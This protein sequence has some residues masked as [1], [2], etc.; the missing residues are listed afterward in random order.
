[1]NR[2]PPD[3]I[4]KKLRQEVNFGC[5]Y[6]DCGKPVLS[7]HHFDPLWSDKEHHDAAGMIALCP[8]HHAFADGGHYTREQLKNWKRNPNSIDKVRFEIPWLWDNFVYEIGTSYSKPSSTIYLNGHKLLQATRDDNSSPWKLSVNILND[9]GETIAKIDN[10]FLIAPSNFADICLS[11]Q[12]KHLNIT[13]KY[14]ENYLDI[15]TRTIPK[16]SIK[17]Y[18]ENIYKKADLPPE[19]SAI[20]D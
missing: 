20:S 10:N 12:G 18:L 14:N 1:M 9:K 17:S 8:E 19:N 15:S 7:W 13:E 3:H 11:Y 2:N 16:E 4:L 6:P 5:P